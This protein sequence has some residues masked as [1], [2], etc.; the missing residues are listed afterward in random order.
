GGVVVRSVGLRNLVVQ[1][2]SAA[3][4]GRI[5]LR[6]ELADQAPDGIL[7]L[8]SELH[9]AALAVAD[10]DDLA[11]SLA[12]GDHFK[13]LLAQCAL[14]IA[15]RAMQIVDRMLRIPADSRLR[16]WL[17]LGRE[18]AHDGEACQRY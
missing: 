10:A 12:L 4:I 15:Q 6:A 8:A 14:V 11:V 3:T 13:R 18:G 17:R 9:I 5:N 2:T 7:A 1:G 16:R